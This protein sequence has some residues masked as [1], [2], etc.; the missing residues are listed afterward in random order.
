M[1]L[2]RFALGVVL[3]CA[4]TSIA[5]PAPRAAAPLQQASETDSAKKPT[6]KRLTDAP[7]KQI[8]IDE[9]IAAYS[10]NSPCPYNTD[11]RRGGCGRRSAYSRE[12]GEAPVEIELSGGGSLTLPVQTLEAADTI[13]GAQRRLTHLAYFAGGIETPATN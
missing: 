5:S 2:P 8:L 13:P 1:R 10:G 3:L 12:G 7:I 4:T 11:S 6:K 9:S